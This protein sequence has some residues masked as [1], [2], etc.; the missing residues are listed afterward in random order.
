MNDGMP[1]QGHETTLKESGSVGQPQSIPQQLTIII[2]TS[3]TPSA[4]STDLLATVFE[5]YH[6]HCA[7]LI[8]CRV[9]VVFDTYDH[10]TQQDRLKRGQVTAELA[11]KYDVYKTRAKEL[12]L[13][14]Y[15]GGGIG[16]EI[17]S[18]K[19][20]TVSQSTALRALPTTMCLIPYRKR[21]TNG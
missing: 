9:I 19:R 20:A 10:I 5:S 1:S 16:L 17:S 13:Q 14:Q 8:D 11:R 15:A 7:Y 3:P 4:P 21:K 6:K 18:S 2:T 12:V